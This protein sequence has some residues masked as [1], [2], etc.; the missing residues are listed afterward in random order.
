MKTIAILKDIGIGITWAWEQLSGKKALIGTIL[1]LTS[2]VLEQVVASIWGIRTE[3][4]Y[5]LIETLDWTGIA[6][7]GAGLAHKAIKRVYEPKETLV[8]P[9][10]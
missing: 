4:L 7:G 8:G 6:F 1:L 9:S 3:F 5:K 10:A 2:A